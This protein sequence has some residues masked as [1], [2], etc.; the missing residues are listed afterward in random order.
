MQN[1]RSRPVPSVS[2]R[3][4][5]LSTLVGYYTMLALQLRVFRVD[6]PNGIR[7]TAF[8]QLDGRV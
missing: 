5:E 1:S 6:L 7:V 2:A 3:L 8:D 4:F